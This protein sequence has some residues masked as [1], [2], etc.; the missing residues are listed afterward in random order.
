MYIGTKIIKA[1]PKSKDDFL[2]ETG[3]PTNLH[4]KD[5]PGYKI[6]YADNYISWSPKDVFE[7]AYRKITDL[8]KEFLK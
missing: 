1:I 8:E 7:S 3:K 4:D 6:V 5:E 2:M